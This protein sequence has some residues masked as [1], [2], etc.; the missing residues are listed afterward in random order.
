MASIARYQVILHARTKCLDEEIQR[1][2][3]DRT[4]NDITPEY[5]RNMAL[6]NIALQRVNQAEMDLRE[7]R[8]FNEQLKNDN[9]SENVALWASAQ[10][11]PFPLPQVIALGILAGCAA[12]IVRHN[13]K[14]KRARRA[15]PRPDSEPESPL[16]LVPDEDRRSR[17]KGTPLDIAFPPHEGLGGPPGNRLED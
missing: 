13:L 5:T 14:P 2:L 4:I 15:R 1:I 17:A 8:L 16:I 3:N 12:A 6:Q 9:V 10:V 7:S 11:P